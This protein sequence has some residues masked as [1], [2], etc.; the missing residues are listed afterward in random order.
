MILLTHRYSNPVLPVGGLMG[1]WKIVC[2]LF[3]HTDGE[4]P[5]G[6]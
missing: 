2:K 5:E 6:I 1:D 3:A 4:P